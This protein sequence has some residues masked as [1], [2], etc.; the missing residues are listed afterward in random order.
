VGVALGIALSNSTNAVSVSSG[1]VGKRLDKL[2]E[3]FIKLDPKE[4]FMALSDDL[5]RLAAQDVVYLNRFMATSYG[6]PADAPP[7]ALMQGATE[8]FQ[9]RLRQ[10]PNGSWLFTASSGQPGVVGLDLGPAGGRGNWS[11]SESPSTGIQVS[12]L[13]PAYQEPAPDPDSPPAI[14]IVEMIFLT[15]VIPAVFTE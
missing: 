3:I 13:Y 9:G 11:S 5:N 12:I 4:L 1:F 10:A 6:V 14:S 2:T 8:V 7:G 15:N